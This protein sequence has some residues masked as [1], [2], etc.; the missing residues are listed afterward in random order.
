MPPETTAPT[1]VAGS[2]SARRRVS[3]RHAAGDEHDEARRIS[4]GC[5]TTRGAGESEMSACELERPI[6]RTR[7][8]GSLQMFSFFYPHAF[9]VA[10]RFSI[11]S[12]P[13]PTALSEGRCRGQG[14]QRRE[15]HAGRSGI[16]PT[17]LTIPL[18]LGSTPRCRH[19]LTANKQRGASKGRKHS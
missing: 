14:H 7:S 16:A 13:P 17:F 1:R 3:L 19:R 9:H 4:G 15:Y 11:A 5:A 6:S 12:P 18:W 2:S 8:V 10:Y